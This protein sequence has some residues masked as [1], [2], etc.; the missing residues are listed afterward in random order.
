MAVSKF[1]YLL[2]FASSKLRDDIEIAKIALSNDSSAL[3][4]VSKNLRTNS[5]IIEIAS[6]Q[7]NLSQYFYQ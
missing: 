5:E 2:Q 7:L 4:Y 6:K 3:K 1:G